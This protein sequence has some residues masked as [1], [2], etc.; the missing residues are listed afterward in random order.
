[1]GIGYPTLFFLPDMGGLTMIMDY[2]GPTWFA[3]V[4]SFAIAALLGAFLSLLRRD[5]DAG[6]RVAR[7]KDG[8]PDT[9]EEV[10]RFL[11]DDH[12]RLDG[13]LRRA[14]ADPVHVD[15]AAYAEFRAGQLKHI[16]MEEKI[17][18]PAAKRAND[19]E[20]LPIV[21]KLRR[22][23]AA[24]AALLMLPPT[25]AIVAALQTILNG[26]NAI[27]EDP[28]GLYGTCDEILATEA[29]E[30]LACLRAAPGVRVN[31]HADAPLV[32]GAAR[33]ALA[34]AGFDLQLEAA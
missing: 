3:W 8:A 7:A 22:D 21:A 24:I 4:A 23:H 30:I 28:G 1:M 11:A 10:S 27:E 19:G 9:Y 31:Q 12:V 18:F 25:P 20:P 16:S 26:H 33:R 14:L 6:V 15:R 32:F 34:R 29:D 17:L 2:S 13:L 5:R